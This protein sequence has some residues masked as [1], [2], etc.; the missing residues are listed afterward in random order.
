[1]CP[2][3]RDG[4]IKS[5]LC[6]LAFS[7]VMVGFSFEKKGHTKTYLKSG[8]EIIC[9]V[10]VNHCS[11]WNNWVDPHTKHKS[12][13]FVSQ[14][15]VKSWL[16]CV[17]CLFY[18]LLLVC[19][20]LLQPISSVQRSQPFSL[21]IMIFFGITALVWDRI[22]PQCWDE[23]ITQATVRV[24]HLIHPKENTKSGSQTCIS[25]L[26]KTSLLKSC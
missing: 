21:C 1:M 8:F 6:N 15:H 11:C 2:V 12:M 13:S 16:C 3:V 19:C 24:W 17:S 26:F 10:Q 5:F 18:S 25:S 4:R 14:C 22:S 7:P 23:L 20:F 9:H